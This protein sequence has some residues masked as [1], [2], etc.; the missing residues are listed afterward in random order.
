M[1]MAQYYDENGKSLGTD[2]NDDNKNKYYTNKSDFE[3]AQKNGNWGHYSR[4]QTT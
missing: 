1:G 3:S 2:N 4:K